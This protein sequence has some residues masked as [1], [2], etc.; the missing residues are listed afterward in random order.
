MEIIS[1]IGHPIGYEQSMAQGSRFTL[2]QRSVGNHPLPGHGPVTSGNRPLRNRLPSG[3][4]GRRDSPGCPMW[5]IS[6]L[7]ELRAADSRLADYRQQGSCPNLSMVW[8]RNGNGSSRKLFL[9]NDVASTLAR[10]HESV[11]FEDSTDFFSRQDLQL[12]QL[13]PLLE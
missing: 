5:A 3:V 13:P 7:L 9:H 1:H 8:N 10:F 4:G 12:N 2:P 11:F 6:D